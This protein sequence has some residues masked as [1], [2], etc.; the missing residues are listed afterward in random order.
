LPDDV[1]PDPRK[2]KEIWKKNAQE[3][4]PNWKGVR[5]EG[6]SHWAQVYRRARA[7]KERIQGASKDGGKV[8]RAILPFGT[9]EFQTR[10]GTSIPKT[11]G[12]Q[13]FQQ[14]PIVPVRKLGGQLKKTPDKKPTQG[15][16]QKKGFLWGGAHLRKGKGVAP[17][18][19]I[20]KKSLEKWRGKG[21]ALATGYFLGD[22][23]R[24]NGNEPRK[25]KLQSGKEI[26]F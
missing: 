16:G 19:K 24:E 7:A 5:R 23:W 8:R 21:L 13:W 10:G 17:K 9:N 25:E 22:G 11:V 15:T 3:S 18:R 14:K 4:R 20:Q 2:K 1:L 12:S 6:E 26:E